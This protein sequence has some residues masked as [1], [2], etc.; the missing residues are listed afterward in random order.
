MRKIFEEERGKK[1]DY[2]WCRYCKGYHLT[3]S[4]SLW[5]KF[6]SIDGKAI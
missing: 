3:I 1:L 5:E 6:Y 4:E 2:Y